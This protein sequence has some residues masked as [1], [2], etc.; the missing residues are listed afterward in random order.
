M[1]N[2]PQPSQPFQPSQ[3]LQP[4]QTP[5]PPKLEEPKEETL[6]FL[7]RGETKTMQRD[8][9]KLREAEAE[10]AKERV[11]ALEEQK[12][13]TPSAKPGVLMPQESPSLSKETAPQEETPQ[14]LIPQTQKPHSSFK[15]IIIRVAAVV[16]ILLLGG[17]FYWL[18]S[19]GKLP[20]MEISRP[21][22]EVVTEAPVAEEVA[23]EP[24]II[25]PEALISAGVTETIE[26]ANITAIPQMLSQIMDKT[27]QAEGYARILFQNTA[28]NKI[29]GLKEFLGAFPV[30]VPE[31]ILAGLDDDFTL[32][33][34]SKEGVNRLGFVAKTNT[35][36][37]LPLLGWER[38]MEAD[39]NSLF[40]VL[41]KEG[42]TLASS[43]KN[44]SYHGKT[45]RFLTISKEDFGI[46]YAL[47][48]DYFVFAT[49][50]ES[51]KK[52]FGAIE[53]VELEKQLGQLFIVGFDGTALTPELTDFF[54]KYRPG[55]VL[56]LSKNIENEEQLKKL[57]SDLQTLSLQET[58]L[59]LFISVDQ[60][61]GVI[62]R[63]EFLQEKTA[64]SEIENVNQAYQIGLARGEELKAL[65][66]NLNLAPLLDETQEGDFLFNRAFQKD[67]ATTGNLA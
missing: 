50:F 51:M 5:Q 32:F 43:F 60:E 35:D 39:T 64:Q 42:K 26:I 15:K 30:T 67:A 12:K 37:S 7:K 48:N 55:G 24:E 54:K 57:I 19:V 23:E 62:S 63:V 27:Y 46:C 44:S 53:A 13:A 36:I 9:A 61:G 38:T 41:G 2:T 45:F 10:I 65:G 49:S 1:E 25:I 17:F 66:I 34:Y 56:L 47:L 16:I 58:G 28:E 6:E 4:S 40:A 31:E 18:F 59:P 21:E 33:V 11:A 29:V 22:T 8:L 20:N 52:T 14:T 3:P